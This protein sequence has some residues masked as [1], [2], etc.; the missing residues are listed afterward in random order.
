MKKAF[1]NKKG[2]TISDRHRNEDRRE[3]CQI[4]DIV[5]ITLESHP[6]GSKIYQTNSWN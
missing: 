5:V 1:V 2:H 4:K 6:P 3:K